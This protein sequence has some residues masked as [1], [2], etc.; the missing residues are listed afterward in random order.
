MRIK[1]AAAAL[2]A[3]LTIVGC[4]A[5]PTASSPA[6]SGSAAAGKTIRILAEGGGVGL[7]KGIATQ[8]TKDTGI[9]VEFVEV[10][11]ADVHDKLAA[12]I[13]TGAGSYD[14]ATIDVIWMTEFGPSLQPLD[15][16]MTAPVTADLAD[17]LVSDA[18]FEGHFIGMPQW[19]NAEILFYRSDLFADPKEKAAFKTAYGYDLVPP[20]TWQQYR[21]VAKF[22]NRPSEKLYGTAVKGA[23]ETEWLAYILQAG[24]PTVVLDKSGGVIIDD[25]NHTKAL[26]EYIAPYCTD[27]VG[28]DPA[29]T[30][31]AAAQNTFYQGQSAM[32]LFWAHAYR[33]TPAD[34]KVA[35]K[36][37]VAPMI[38]GPSGIAA[39]PG[40]WYNVVPKDS[41]NADLAKQYVKYA[42]DHNVLGIDAP[43]GLA[44]RTSAYEQFQAKAGYEAYKPLLTT[45]NAPATNGRPMDVHWQ[46]ITDEVLT[47]TV[48]KALTCKT[49][50]KDVLAEAKQKIA[51]ILKQ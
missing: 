34:S 37:G 38:A 17:A 4:A 31:W 26:E 15:D 19:A 42:Y 27:K 11:Y 36:V 29:T 6:T 30:D 12:D 3:S 20:T 43:L 41:P 51:A 40:P 25:A 13:S 46:Q 16:V 10:P 50:V 49:P 23:V 35:G 32:M 18:K 47:P 33:M 9:K 14:L 7:Q 24:S 48:Q 8:F 44:A 39:I 5:S 1:F 22:F 28:P 45:L 21:D 2:A